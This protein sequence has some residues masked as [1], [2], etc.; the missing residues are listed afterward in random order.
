MFERARNP[1]E[2]ERSAVHF[3]PDFVARLEGLT[4][5]VRAAREREEGPGAHGQ[6]GGGEE[7]VGYRPYRPG[8]DVRDLDWAAY[9]RLDRPYVR[10]RR[11]ETS[12]RWA[13]LL[14]ASA[15]MGVGRPHKLQRASEVAVALA[16]C[17]LRTGATASVFIASADSSRAAEMLRVRVASDL[18]RCI[19]FFE[20]R[21]AHGTRGANAAFADPRL[22]RAGRVFVVGDQLG[23]EPRD[24]LALARRGR[25]LTVVQILATHELAPAAA[26]AV[27]WLD[28]ESG[29]RL[30]LALS[31]D[32]IGAYSHALEARLDL[33][34]TTCA[35]HGIAQRCFASTSAFEDVVRAVLV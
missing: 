4:A 14:D 29:E 35:R 17:G 2:S 10:V 22:A 1:E 6:L 11:R 30:E 34:R 21:T 33:W 9:A 13:V 12:E 16:F 28:P 26:S 3:A 31:P 20:G 32:A 7:F 8:E 15:S 27:E 18:A 24:V 5:R 25:A 19:A 23:Y